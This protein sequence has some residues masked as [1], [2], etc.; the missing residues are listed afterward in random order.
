MTDD[1]TPLRTFQNILCCLG[2]TYVEKGGVMCAYGG[3]KDPQLCTAVSALPTHVGAVP[4]LRWGHS[5]RRR[6]AFHSS[7]PT[8]V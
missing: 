6:S 5:N 4:H 3:P 8:I 7:G 2:G 1:A